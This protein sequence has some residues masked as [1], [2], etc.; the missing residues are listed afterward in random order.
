MAAAIAAWGLH[1]SHAERGRATT[2]AVSLWRAGS[3]CGDAISNVRSVYYVLWTELTCVGVQ[4]GE[5][6]ANV[7]VI[8]QYPYLLA[9][10]RSVYIL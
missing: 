1:S 10:Y 5:N 8:P 6:V 9:L 4:N 7:Q 2:S 3:R